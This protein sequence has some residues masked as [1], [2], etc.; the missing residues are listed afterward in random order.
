MDYKWYR[1]QVIKRHPSTIQE[2]E[3]YKRLE[4]FLVDF[5]GGFGAE[6]NAWMAK[7]CFSDEGHEDMFTE[8]QLQSLINC[9]LYVEFLPEAQKRWLTERIQ[10]RINEINDFLKCPV[11]VGDIND[12]VGFE[13]EECEEEIR[14]YLTKKIRH[15]WNTGKP[16]TKNF[17]A[18]G[19]EVGIPYSS[20]A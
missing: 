5:F 16:Q 1:V 19:N 18:C 3:E 6:S 12:P 15:G 10:S 14:A 11:A 2:F 8:E 4:D 9:G 7:A 17:G 20:G 13:D